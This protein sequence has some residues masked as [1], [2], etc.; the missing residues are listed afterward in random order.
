MIGTAHT[1]RSPMMRANFADGAEQEVRTPPDV[2]ARVV[3]AFGGPTFAGSGI[4][5]DPCAPSKSP[6]SF[7][8]DRYVRAGEGSDGLGG[9]SPDLTWPDRT[10]ANP[11]FAD[12]VPWLAKARLHAA[13]AHRPRIVLLVPARTHRAW[14]QAAV[15][16]TAALG[17]AVAFLGPVKFVG[18]KGAF[19]A[20]LCLI[21]W[22][23]V[24]EGPIV[25]DFRRGA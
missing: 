2:I 3:R 17:G 8:A 21:S 5:L 15:L 19:P 9:L 20:P 6:P 16:S 10:Y 13:Q 7:H 25:G 24:A 4:A 11:E 14:F 22:N 12:L 18:H 1:A 23:C